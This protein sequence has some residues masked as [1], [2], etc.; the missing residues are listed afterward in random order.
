MHN[1]PEFSSIVV[2]FSLVYIVVEC[3]KQICTN[4]LYYSF[5]IVLFI[6]C[7]IQQIILFI[8]IAS[9]NHVNMSILI[10]SFKILKKAENN[11]EFRQNYFL[12]CTISKLMIFIIITNNILISKKKYTSEVLRYQLFFHYMSYSCIQLMGYDALHLQR[13]AVRAWVMMHYTFS[14][15]Q[16]MDRDA[17]HLQRHLVV[18]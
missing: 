7:T 3:T 13:Y 11:E 1:L 16:Y 15:I 10:N 6:H 17:L 2:N 12:A 4:K 8:T 9:C 18:V 5:N 14:G